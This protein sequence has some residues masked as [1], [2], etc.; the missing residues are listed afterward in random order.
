MTSATK[1]LVTTLFT[2][3][4]LCSASSATAAAQAIVAKIAS[5]L[6]HTESGNYTL[7]LN[8][9]DALMTLVMRSS[10]VINTNTRLVNLN[11]YPEQS[12]FRSFQGSIHGED[13]SWVRLGVH[14]DSL[15]GVISTQGSRYQLSGSASSLSLIHISEP[16]RPY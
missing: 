15:S 8:F 1:K 11:G 12:S 9:G 14:G 5:P 10:A 13:N 16:T 2:L 4:C 3:L 6:S 7:G